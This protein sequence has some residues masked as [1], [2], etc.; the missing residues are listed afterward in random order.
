MIQD[1]QEDAIV[2]TL[3]EF[4]F[5]PPVKFD[6]C[7][8]PHNKDLGTADSLRI[9]KDKLKVSRNLHFHKKN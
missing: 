7:T 4:K 6:F 5:D 1:S 3:N 9:I 2:R 8:I